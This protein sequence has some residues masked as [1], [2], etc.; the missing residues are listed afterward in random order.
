VGIDCSIS[1]ERID[2]LQDLMDAGYTPNKASEILGVHHSFTDRRIRRGLL[3]V[4]TP[5]DEQDEKHLYQNFEWLWEEDKLEEITSEAFFNPVYVTQ[6]N[7]DM[8]VLSKYVRKK[9][10]NIK[11]YLAN[12]ELYH[13]VTEIFLR[14]VLC[15]EY[16]SLENFYPR[17]A[18]FMGLDNRC[19]SCMKKIK[20]DW[21][22]NNPEVLKVYAHNRRALENYLPGS[23]NQEDFHYLKAYFSNSCALTKITNDIDVDHFIPLSWGHGG[24]YYENM[25]PLNAS[26]NRSKSDANPFDWFES[27]KEERG[28]STDAWN[29]L[30]RYLSSING[31]TTDEYKAFVNWC[32]ENQRTIDEIRADSRPSIEI[33]REVTGFQFPIRVNFT[34]PNEIGNRLESA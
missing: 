23:F 18:T 16:H 21:V 8:V 7:E 4:Y 19:N 34:N 12:K 2:K 33:W 20:A 17:R 6:D 24:S 32:Y 29:D 26:L 11:R 22:R 10:G 27:A 13:L 1:D 28:I 30:I 5:F 9:H 25:Y 14:C 31:L 3:E 15:T